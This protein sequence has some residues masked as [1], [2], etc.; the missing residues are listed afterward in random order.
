MLVT[1]DTQTLIWSVR[2]K[3]S[4]HDQYRLAEAANLIDLLGDQ[5][6]DVVL[7]AVVL[8]EYLVGEEYD[9][10]NVVAQ[11]LSQNYQVLPYDANAARLAAELRSD[12]EF[13]AQAKEM[14]GYTR[15]VIAADIQLVATAVVNG[16]RAVVANDARTRAVAKR[17]GIDGWDI[18]GPAKVEID[19]PDL[20]GQ[21]QLK[22]DDPN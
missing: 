2:Q 7:T 18:T 13:I 14:P 5:G 16:V 3:A 1:F 20:P 9:R 4:P 10:R 22:F 17:A 11:F 19:S 21:G 15:A 6:D 8:G 12:R